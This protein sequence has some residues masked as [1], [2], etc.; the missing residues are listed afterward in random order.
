MAKK[1]TNPKIEFHVFRKDGN[2]YFGFKIDPRIEKIFKKSSENI[3]ESQSWEGLKFYSVPATT[4]SQDYKNLLE[5][6]G[7]RDAFGHKFYD[8][9]SGKFNIAFIRT[10]GG[11][12][13]IKLDASSLSFAIVASKMKNVLQFLRTYHEEFL[14]NY[15][16][17]ATL[18]FDAE[19]TS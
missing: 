2:T 9:I 16:V 10:V 1:Q 19:I 12:G 6:Y 8:D 11:E 5:R 4:E 17:S 7:L 18:T 13:E 3:V 15:K 14:R